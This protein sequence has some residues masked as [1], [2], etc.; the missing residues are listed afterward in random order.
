M[1]GLGAAHGE[2]GAGQVGRGVVAIAIEAQDAVQ[3]LGRHGPGARAAGAPSIEQTK[4]PRPSNV[5]RMRRALP[6]D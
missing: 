4:D 5:G 3:L 6:G 2:A 1:L